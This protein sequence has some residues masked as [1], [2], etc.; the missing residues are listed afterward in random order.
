MKIFVK[1]LSQTHIVDVEDESTM[2]N[3]KLMAKTEGTCFFGNRCVDDEMTVEQCQ[4]RE[5]STIDVIVPVEGG[6]GKKKK[7]R[8][9]TKPKKNAH[10][11]KNVPMRVLKYYKVEGEG[12]NVKVTHQRMECPHPNCGAGIFMAA[13]KDRQTCG[14]CHLTYVFQKK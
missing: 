7:K 2:A 14:K 13:H 3:L 8:V 10:R 11:H 6:K 1:V 9:F 4:L 12:D 5:Y